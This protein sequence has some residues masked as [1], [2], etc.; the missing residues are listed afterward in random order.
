MNEEDVRPWAIVYIRGFNYLDTNSL[1]YNMNGR[2][3]LI[4]KVRGDNVYL[5]SVRPNNLFSAKEFYYPI[6]LKS[7]KGN[8]NKC[9]VNLRYVYSIKKDVLIKKVCELKSELNLNTKT[10]FLPS[11]YRDGILK[12]IEKICFVDDYNNIINDVKN[13]KLNTNMFI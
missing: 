10:K 2:P 3:F 1:C 4:Y 11:K 7:Y 5:F 8:L 9:Y 13:G 12:G 6:T